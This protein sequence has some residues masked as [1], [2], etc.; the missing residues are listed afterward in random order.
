MSIACRVV[1]LKQTWNRNI[2]CTHQ[3]S[4]TRFM[5]FEIVIILSLLWEMELNQILNLCRICIFAFRNL[6]RSIW[7]IFAWRWFR[8]ICES[9][10][11]FLLRTWCFADTCPWWFRSCRKVCWCRTRCRLPS[12]LFHLLSLVVVGASIPSNSLSYWIQLDHA[13]LFSA[14]TS[15][16]RWL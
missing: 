5:S 6:Y 8:S 4:Y 16:Y 10:G 15:V 3:L 13:L 12:S 9:R 1:T 14:D 7:S 2:G 11:V